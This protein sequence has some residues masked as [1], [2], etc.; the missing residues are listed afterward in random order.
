[1]S[2]NQDLIEKTILQGASGANP[3]L[4]NGGRLNAEQRD[5]FVQLVQDSSVLLKHVRFEQMRNLR[6]DIDRIFIGAPVTV[7][8]TEDNAGTNSSRPVFSQISLSADKLRSDWEIST[9]ALQDNIE[10]GSLE[11]TIM[12]MMVKRISTDIEILAIQ[13]DVTKTGLSSYEALVGTAD[14]YDVLTAGAWQVDAAGATITKELF[15]DALRTM[16]DQYLQ[17]PDLRWIVSRATM[18]DWQES[19]AGRETAGGDSALAGKTMSPYGIPMLVVP[20]MPINAPITTALETPARVVSTEAGPFEIVLDEND[21]ITIETNAS[22]APDTFVLDPGVYLAH[23]M[24]AHITSKMAT[25]TTDDITVTADKDG[26]LV[27]ET[28]G[29]GLSASPD[30]PAEIE[31]TAVADDAYEELGL[32]EAVAAGAAQG[33]NAAAGNTTNNGTFLWLANP[34]NFIFGMVD[35]TRI[36]SEF[37]RK[38][39]KIENTIFNQVAFGVENLEAIVKITGIARG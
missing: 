37:N 27:F 12:E 2:D 35:D 7:A 18:I 9:E 22:G 38:S 8:A 26:Y 30:D 14:G 20:N 4:T 24:A 33:A 13:G 11:D 5:R 34:K 19:I 28:I 31:F 32:D 15:S 1:M 21:T 6:K 3:G 16:P 36:Y 39:D 17:D 25:A 29:I 10:G 23:E